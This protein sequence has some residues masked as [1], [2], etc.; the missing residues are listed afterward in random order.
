MTALHPSLRLFASMVLL[1]ALAAAPA[2]AQQARTITFDEAIRI[3]LEQN[4]GL[5]RSANAVALQSIDAA[6]ERNDF[7][8]SLTLSSNGRQSYGRT[9]S[10]EDLEFVNETTESF[11]ASVN[12]GVNLFNGFADV[13]SLQRARY[14]LEASDLDY[15]RQRQTVV[16]QVMSNYLDLIQR[17]EQVVIQEENLAAQR[18][19]LAQI[20]EFVR[21]GSR[22][23]SDQFQQ[24]ANTA[25]AELALLQAR[26]LAQLA[27][28]ALIQVLQLDPIGVYQFTVPE[29][30]EAALV[31]ETY[32]VPSLL[33]TA[34]NQRL[35]LQ[36]QQVSIRAAEEG[37]RVARSSMWPSLGLNFGYGTGWNSQFRIAGE[38]V[39]LFDQ[40]DQQRGGSVSLSLSMPIFDRF[41][42]RTSVQQARVQFENA[43]LDLENLQQDVALQVRQAYL[44][45]LTDELRLDVT[46][47]QLRAA[48]QALEAEQ[49]RYNVG[50]STLVELSQTRAS[51]VQAQS[52]RADAVYSFLFR[53]RLLEYYLGVLDPARR[54]FE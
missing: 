49:E 39:P 38:P 16:F 51:F 40:F 26:R 17:R 4:Y 29:I 45:Y 37:I 8:P 21:V 42:T 22:P 48:E 14:A 25:N 33:E 31:P 52:D 2:R 28:V 47:A 11:S 13:A 35:D 53:K 32:S 18:Q 7:L 19:L 3:A 50:A 23:M 5:K 9:F 54:L 27:E 34:F 30:D 15:E 1:A 24:Q 12:T 44:D 10:Q 6:R 36:A 20:E 41:A 46:E 43:R